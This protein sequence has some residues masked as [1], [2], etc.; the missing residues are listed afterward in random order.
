MVQ[1]YICVCSKICNIIDCEHRVPHEKNF[2]CE[3]ICD[4]CDALDCIKYEG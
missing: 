2:L 4:D 3:S 1:L